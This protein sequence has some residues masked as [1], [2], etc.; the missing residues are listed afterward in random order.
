VK[1]RRVGV[2][3]QLLL[4]TKFRNPFGVLQ[5]DITVLRNTK[6][7]SP[8]YQVKEENAEKITAGEKTL[9]NFF[10]S[11]MNE[12]ALNKLIASQ[13]EVVTPHVFAH[14]DWSTSVLGLMPG[15]SA[16]VTNGKV[17]PVFRSR[18]SP[19]AKSVAPD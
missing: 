9:A 10:V 4:K 12:D 15:Q 2:S 5:T 7:L 19:L 13:P 1:C 18:C 8:L 11:G 3:V 16:I 14:S 17:R 6:Y